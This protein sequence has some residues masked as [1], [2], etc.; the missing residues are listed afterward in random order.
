M[1]ACKVRRDEWIAFM[2]HELETGREKA[3][4]DHLG[5]C[6]SCRD[7]VEDLRALFEE[8]DALGEEARAAL[9]SVDWDA[10]PARIAARLPERAVSTP[11][12][13]ARFR[14]SV[15]SPRLRPALAGLLAG[16]ILGGAAAFF[17][18]RKP[19][20][21]G[22]ASDFFASG[23]FLDRVELELARR[24]TLDYLDKG[25]YLIL[26][27]LETPAGSGRPGPDAAAS[28]EARD[29]IASKKYLNPQLD[30]FGMAKAKELCDQIELLVFELTQLSPEV[31][32]AEVDRIR[33]MV[34]DRQLLMKI[35]LVKKELERS[36]V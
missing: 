6:R 9:A 29:L 7:E 17:A 4:S 36:E 5:T 21:R 2:S 13:G 28:R 26:D 20:G 32:A 18:L 22:A 27:V 15:W 12:F 8:A 16:I 14:A 31:G 35:R 34:S 10:I 30:K 19:S 33:G 25:Q 1:S 11:G 23:E 3:L 24:Q